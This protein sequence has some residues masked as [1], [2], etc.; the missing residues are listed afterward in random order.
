MGIRPKGIVGRFLD[1]WW[2][3]AGTALLICSVA[4]FSPFHMPGPVASIFLILMV[5]F[6]TLTVGIWN[7]ARRRGPQG[8]INL[9]MLPFCVMA[10]LIHIGAF[11]F[12]GMF[13][14]PSEDGFGKDIVIPPDMKTASPLPSREED[15]SG[16]ALDAEGGQLVG[17]FS[18]RDKWP[19]KPVVDTDI[20][21][22]DAFAG[23]KRAV[24]LRHLATSAEW[25]L[26]R[27]RGKLY[28]YRRFVTDGGRWS[29]S[30]NGFYSAFDF[31]M[32]E[33]LHYQ[34]R[35]IIGIDGPVM[36]R[37][38]RR[39]TTE[40]RAGSGMITLK[41]RKSTNPGYESY[42]VLRSRG[43]AIEIYEE[44]E[45]KKRPFTAL[46]LSQ[47]SSELQR[48]LDSNERR[49]RGFDTSLM[50][51]ASV[52]KGP[53]DIWLVNGMQGGIYLV[54]AYVNPG[55]PGHAYVK[56]YEATKN[57]PLSTGRIPARSTEFIGWSGNPEE[58]FFYNTEITVYE[59]DWGTYYPARFE[60]WH[61]PDS[62]KPERKLVEKVFKIEG[63]QR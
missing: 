17:I 46:A 19:P 11:L 31:S 13:S 47:V 1:N 9:V 49:K 62:G 43:P 15:K 63:W 4:V 28:A 53:A 61:V 34:F 52:R 8:F 54:Y 12:A 22:L 42:L 51:D 48:L 27:E 45:T 44:E 32:F 18:R 20:S 33:R 26:T 41:V 23:P 14:G 50:P 21:A 38:W 24:L 39:K 37:P 2:L 60:L 5:L 29:N 10:I 7:I 55:E 16:K 58:K 40:T 35:I 59:G 30:L 6:W 3:P 56:V 36:Q 25:C 57:T